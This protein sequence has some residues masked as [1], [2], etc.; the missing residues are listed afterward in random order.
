M[1]TPTARIRREAGF[2]LI[3]LVVGMILTV[4]VLG[5]VMLAMTSMFKGVS[6]SSVDRKAAEL[7]MAALG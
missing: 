5:A 1:L 2:T 4:L 7:Q 3:E 6:E